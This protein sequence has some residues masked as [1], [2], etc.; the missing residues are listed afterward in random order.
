MLRKIDAEMNKAVRDR[1][2]YF[3]NNTEVKVSKF[4][5]VYVFLFGNLIA[6]FSGNYSMVFHKGCVEMDDLEMKKSGKEKWK[7]ATTKRRLN[8]L[9]QEFLPDTKLYQDKGEWYF[10][11]WHFSKDDYSDHIWL[12]GY[13][14]FDLNRKQ[15]LKLNNRAASSNSIIDYELLTRSTKEVA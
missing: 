6:S 3:N 7:T 9:L 11:R 15:L 12:L 14:V 1:V 5:I 13:A 2:P 10:S 8:A 4:G